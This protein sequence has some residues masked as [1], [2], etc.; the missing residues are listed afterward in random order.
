MRR[1]NKC[2]AIQTNEKNET[3]NTQ[4]CQAAE[5]HQPA[6][7]TSLSFGEQDSWGLAFLVMVPKKDD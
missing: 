3:R 4:M 2:Q 1:G 7:L 5:K 6:Q